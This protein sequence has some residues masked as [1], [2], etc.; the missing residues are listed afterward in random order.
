MRDGYQESTN[1]TSSV[2]RLR[3]LIHIALSLIKMYSGSCKC[4]NLQ[5]LG[6]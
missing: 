6:F 5:L 1:F 2:G 4:S 3:K